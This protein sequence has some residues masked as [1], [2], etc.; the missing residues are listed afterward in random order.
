MNSLQGYRVSAVKAGASPAA[1]RIR[2]GAVVGLTSVAVLLG[3]APKALGPLDATHPAS[4][5]A[6]EAAPREP[7]TMLGRPGLGGTSER[8]APAPSMSQGH[9]TMHGATGAG[10]TGEKTGATYVC[11]MHPDV[12]QAGPGKCSRC[13]MAL[14]REGGD[15]EQKGG[16]AH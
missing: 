14:R 10:G 6:A 5:E 13:G 1:G 8:E 16:H 7:E 12:R 15:G 9:G 4:L 3:C 2:L 11:P